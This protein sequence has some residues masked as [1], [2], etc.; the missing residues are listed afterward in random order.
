M[1]L[2]T[3]NVNY[4]WTSFKEKRR[5]KTKLF[6]KSESTHGSLVSVIIITKVKA[7]EESVREIENN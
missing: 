5:P 3:M 1:C 2:L 7:R 6:H 4:N